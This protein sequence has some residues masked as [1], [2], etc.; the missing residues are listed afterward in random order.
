MS[1]QWWQ[2][3]LS[4]WQYPALVPHCIGELKRSIGHC[5]FRFGEAFHHPELD[6]TWRYMAR[7]D[8]YFQPY[9]VKAMESLAIDFRL[10]QKEHGRFLTYNEY[11]AGGWS[12]FDWVL[13]VSNEFDRI[14]KMG[15][16]L[17]E[18]HT[19]LS[20]MEVVEISPWREDAF[21]VLE[22]QGVSRETA[23]AHWRRIIMKGR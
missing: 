17:L 2:D 1:E 6:F 7:C 22:R 23:N 19:I 14:A 5:K 15:I 12:K 8:L 4:T 18:S 21:L 10:Y 11:W 13:D 20:P 16:E 3:D 9:E